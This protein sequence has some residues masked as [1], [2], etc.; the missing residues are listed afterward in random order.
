MLQNMK[1]N[2][3]YFEF[4]IRATLA[5]IA[6]Q[7]IRVVSVAFRSVCSIDRDKEQ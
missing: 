6:H 2:M 3:D 7:W 1:T 4:A 5:S